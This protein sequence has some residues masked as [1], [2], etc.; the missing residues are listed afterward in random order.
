MAASCGLVSKVTVTVLPLVAGVLKVAVSL[1]LELG[2][3]MPGTLLL[4]QL[5]VPDQ[6]AAGPVGPGAADRREG[7]YREQLL[8]A[9]GIVQRQAVGRAAHRNRAGREAEIAAQAARGGDQGVAAR[10]ETAAQA[11]DADRIGAGDGRRAMA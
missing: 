5:P 8:G 4:D 3:L 2:P 6:A 10:R 1:A 7:A 11:G 9:G